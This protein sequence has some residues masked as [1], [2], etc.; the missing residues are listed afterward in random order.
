MTAVG[1]RAGVGG[2][3]NVEATQLNGRDVVLVRSDPTIHRGALDLQSSESITEAARVA[4]RLRIPLV[5]VL[6]SSGT[7]VHAGVTGLHGWGTAARAM[8]ECSGVVPVLM[9]VEGPILSGP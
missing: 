9:V 1:L 4:L 3:I 5:L 8:C 6:S 2:T 7:D